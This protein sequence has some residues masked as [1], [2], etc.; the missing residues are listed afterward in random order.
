MGTILA[1]EGNAIN[2]LVQNIANKWNVRPGS[3][4][5][6]PG[7]I[8]Y[9]AQYNAWAGYLRTQSAAITGNNVGIPGNV[10]VGTPMLWGQMQGLINAGNAIYN[11]CNH[12]EC[13]KNECNRKECNR[14]ECNGS[15][16]G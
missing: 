9:A 13:N 14:R 16:G 12:S 2:N 15:E 10:G 11:W 1:S 6:S 7:G 3:T 8:A 4:P 5:V